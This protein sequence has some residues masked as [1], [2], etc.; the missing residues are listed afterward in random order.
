V[1]EASQAIEGAHGRRFL[2]LDDNGDAAALLAVLLQLEGH[3]VQTAANG[4]ELLT[5]AEQFRPEVLLMDL[6]SCGGEA[7][8]TSRRVREQ[9]WGNSVLIAALTGMG[10]EMDR[11]RAREAGVDLHFI[12]PVDTALLLAIVTRSLNSSRG[13]SNPTWDTSC[14]RAPPAPSRESSR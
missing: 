4:D 12:R 3:E 5:R 11:R 2:I 7:F 10:R 13:L 1:V 14:L 6:Q 8:E 9:P